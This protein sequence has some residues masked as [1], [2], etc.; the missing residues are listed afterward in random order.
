M[1]PAYGRTLC[2]SAFLCV[3]IPAHM[4]RIFK[5]G[6]IGLLARRYHFRNATSLR[7]DFQNAPNVRVSTQTIRNHLHSSCLMARR[8][9]MRIPFTPYHIQE[10]LDWAGQHVGWMLNKWTPVLFYGG[11]KVLHCFYGSTCQS[12]EST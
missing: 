11:V 6:M 9:A 4:V 2:R 10:C 3:P 5:I 12:V 1:A 8:P 7:N